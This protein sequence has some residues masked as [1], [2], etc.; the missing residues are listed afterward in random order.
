MELGTSIR[1]SGA[2]FAYVCYV[3]WYPL[4]FSYMCVGCILTYPA[5]LAVQSETFSEYIIRGFDIKFANESDKF[6]ATKLLSFS[7][8]CKFVFLHSSFFLLFDYTIFRD[9]AVSQFF[10][11]QNHCF[12]I[13]SCCKF[14]KNCFN[15]HHNWHR[16]LLPDFQRFYHGI[17][18]S[19]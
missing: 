4:A 3:K 8:I 19:I 14:C 12:T 2:D 10:L 9:S 17:L 15:L 5:T 11:H 13:S 1:K 16:I 6:W 18:F 7:L